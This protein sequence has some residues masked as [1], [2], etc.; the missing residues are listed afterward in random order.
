MSYC[1]QNHWLKLSNV[2][3][4]SHSI[5]KLN[6]TAFML[7]PMVES[8]DTFEPD[9]IESMIEI[10]EGYCLKYD[11]HTN[12]WS[13]ITFVSED[14]IV[15][16]E[17]SAVFDRIRNQLFVSGLNVPLSIIDL[18]TNEFKVCHEI[19]DR[20]LCDEFSN[21]YMD[22]VLV[23]AE[24]KIHLIGGTM[25]PSHFIMHPE[26]H[27]CHEVENFDVWNIFGHSAIYVASK[28]MIFLIVP[29]RAAAM[30]GLLTYSIDKEEWNAIEGI[31]FR[32]HQFYTMTLARNQQ[33]IIISASNWCDD[34]LQAGSVGHIYV[35]NI[36]D[37][38]K[39]QLRESSIQFP[40]LAWAK[41]NKFRSHHLIQTGD[42][43]RSE[44]IVNGWINDMDNMP[45]LPIAVIQEISCFYM[46][47][48]I[49]WIE[50]GPNN[51]N[52]H[53]VVNIKHILK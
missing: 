40:K 13:V 10:F 30:S 41:E 48:E 43:L 24:G 6:E 18:T 20:L 3:R 35:L 29:P 22:P 2:Y 28:R 21:S 9:D 7:I 46:Q 45:L 53:Y 4:N 37:A 15:F 47:E 17:H 31:Q 51:K 25:N 36:S 50:N 23:N 12:E 33:N 34:K 16:E 49:H 11:V 1:K 32:V 27:F 8:F 38:N 52:D 39:Y 42:S 44:K 19:N 14:H 5:S 26:H